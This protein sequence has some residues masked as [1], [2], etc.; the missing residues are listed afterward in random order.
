MVLTRRLDR[1]EFVRAQSASAHEKE[2]EQH[3]NCIELCR[4]TCILRNLVYILIIIHTT[5]H[6]RT[7]SLWNFSNFIK[8]I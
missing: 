4:Q 2:I 6:S 7:F 1:S 3:Q 8:R 5:V